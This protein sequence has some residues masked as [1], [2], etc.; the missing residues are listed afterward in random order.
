VLEGISSEA[1]KSTVTRTK[2]E[3]GEAQELYLIW[4][5]ND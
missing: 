1:V 5:A 4:I 2:E 3:K